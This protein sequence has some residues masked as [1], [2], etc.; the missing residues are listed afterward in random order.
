MIRRL[1]SHRA[2]RFLVVGGINTVATYGIYVALGLIVEPWLAYTIAYLVGLAWVAFGTSRLVFASRHVGHIAKFM[3]WYL[4]LYLVGRL[5]ILLI[6]PE[7]FAALLISSLVVIGVT[8]PLTYL[9]GRLIF[10]PPQASIS[11][12]SLAREE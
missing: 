1:L 8:V 11:R 3:G 4:A 2:V 10:T 5:I 7:G 6:A 12:T 9:G